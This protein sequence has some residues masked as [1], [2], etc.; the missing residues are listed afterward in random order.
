M[1]GQGYNFT[2]AVLD[3]Y[4]LLSI[5]HV[6]EISKPGT[7]ELSHKLG[8]GGGGGGLQNRLL[9][10]EIFC[11]LVLYGIPVLILTHCP[12]VLHGIQINIL[13]IYH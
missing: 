9:Q 7:L 2:I 1:S 6:C 13:Q 8:G 12:I 5:I 3:S 4:L 10:M 11:I